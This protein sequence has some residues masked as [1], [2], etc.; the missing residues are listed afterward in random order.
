[1]A[2]S[3]ADRFSKATAVTAD[4]DEEEETAA[5]GVDELEAPTSLL[6]TFAFFALVAVLFKCV[7][8]TVSVLPDDDIERPFEGD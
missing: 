6:S 4:D 8:V 5:V 2:R 1:L 3:S 7:S